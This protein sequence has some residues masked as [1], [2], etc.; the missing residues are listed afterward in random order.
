MV[1]INCLIIPCS[2]PIWKHPYLFYVSPLIYAGFSFHL[3]AVCCCRVL[4]GIICVIHAVRTNKKKAGEKDLSEVWET[5]DLLSQLFSHTSIYSCFLGPPRTY[6]S[7][8]RKSIL[9][10]S[11]GMACKF[12]SNKTDFLTCKRLP[13]DFFQ[14][15]CIHHYCMPPWD[16]VS[17][18][19]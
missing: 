17:F 6:I 1:C 11:P 18:H 2:T 7:L 13:L 4:Y 15:D 14:G 10:S 9:K 5:F 19:S 8:T 3:T 12:N 16:C